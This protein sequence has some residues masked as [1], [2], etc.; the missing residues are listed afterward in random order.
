MRI[1]EDWDYFG[2]TKASNTGSEESQ[3]LRL[4]FN[5][6][7][8]HGRTR[9]ANFVVRAKRN[10]KTCEDRTVASMGGKLAKP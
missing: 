4:E 6:C 1:D 3:L 9:T 2:N 10:V 7:L 5:Q 8:Q